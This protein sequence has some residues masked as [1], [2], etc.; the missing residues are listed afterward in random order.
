MTF[1]RRVPKS[2]YELRSPGST[3]SHTSESMFCNNPSIL[4]NEPLKLNFIVSS[5][6]SSKLPSYIFKIPVYNKFN[7]L[8][9][10]PSFLRFWYLDKWREIREN[11]CGK[12]KYF[13]NLCEVGGA[14][15]SDGGWIHFCEGFAFL[16]V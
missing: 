3:G 5:I 13:L 1:L 10:F 11:L 15:F 2:E 7:I 9:Q 8:D 6:M 12:R 4:L 14:V 16:G